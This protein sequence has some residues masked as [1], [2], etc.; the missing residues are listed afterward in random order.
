MEQYQSIIRLLEHCDIDCRFPDVAKAKRILA[1]EF[2]IAP[3]GVISIDGFDYTKNDVFN[4]LEHIDFARRLSIHVLIWRTPVLLHCLEKNEIDLAN[5]VQFEHLRSY[6]GNRQIFDFISPYFAISFAKI[7]GR[8]LKE[9]RFTEASNWLKTLHITDNADD[10]RT[11]LSSTNDYLT[12]FIKLLKNLNDATYKKRLPQLEK[13]FS[14][15]WRKFVNNLP[16][17]F[18]GITNDLLFAMHN[19]T[20]IIKHIDSELCLKMSRQMI[21]VRNIDEELR[22]RIVREHGSIGCDPSEKMPL[23]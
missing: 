5:V 9:A 15:P 2:S 14:Q 1:A 22:E 4:E 13:F 7:M 18:Y 19:F 6:W 21:E 23:H 12:D 10:E 8:L 17:T 20:L 16:Y 3:R 11:A